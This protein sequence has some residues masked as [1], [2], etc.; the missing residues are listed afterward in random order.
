MPNDKRRE[1]AAIIAKMGQGDPAI[2]IAKMRG[3][4]PDDPIDW[5]EYGSEPVT[6]QRM[7]LLESLLGPG[8]PTSAQAQEPQVPD[9]ILKLLMQ[10]KPAAAQQQDGYGL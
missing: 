6:P 9:W 5:N 4:G 7:S 10:R 1:L 2:N 8:I 3:V